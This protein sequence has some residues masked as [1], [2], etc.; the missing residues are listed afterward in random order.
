MI[1]AETYA[2]HGAGG[3]V[4]GL[5]LDRDGVVNVDHGYVHRIDQVTFLPG[6]FDL[7]REAKLRGMPIAI[8]TNQA[9]IGRGY[10]TEDDFERLMGW[11]R[12][13]FTEQGAPLAAVYHA[14]EAPSAATLR[15]KPGPSMLHEAAAAL[16]LCMAASVMVGDRA[17]DMQ[18]ALAAGVGHRWLLPATPREVVEA[19][20][21]T[22]VLA[23]LAAAR[24]LLAA[25]PG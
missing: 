22:V 1:A 25:S 8:V 5:L 9:G 23:D 15:R 3:L 11:M 12:D 17:S 13:R 19:P 16:G 7:A 14:P 20:P 18:A 21:G 6:L 2:I 4:P 24:A 10:Y